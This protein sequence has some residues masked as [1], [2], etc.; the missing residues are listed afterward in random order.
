MTSHNH[1]HNHHNNDNTIS[2]TFVPNSQSYADDIGAMFFSHCFSVNAGHAFEEG[3]IMSEDNGVLAAAASTSDETDGSDD[4]DETRTASTND[5]ERP[6][7]QRPLESKRSMTAHD[8]AEEHSRPKKAS[9]TPTNAPDGANAKPKKSCFQITVE[10]IKYVYSVT[11]LVVSVAIVMAAIFTEQTTMAS[12]V[13]PWLAF[14]VIWALIL[15]LAMMEG[16]QGCLVGLQPI[17]KQL[18]A[19]SHPVSLR[20]TT[21]AHQGDNMRRFIVGRQF[22]VVLVVFIVNRCGAAIGEAPSV[23]GFPPLVNEIF[24][25]SGLAMIMMTITLGQLTAQINASIASLDFI[26]NYGMLFTTYVSLAIEFSGL[27]HAVYLV[28]YIFSKIAGTPIESKE[29]PRRALSNI[30]FWGRVFVS[31]AILGY[32]FAVVLSALF[33]GKTT[34]YA[35]VPGW[36][37]VVILFV[38]MGVVGLL[39][40]VQIAL[41]AVVN[42]PEDEL[43]HHTLAAK[44]CEL[45]FRDRNLPAFLIGRQIFTTICM[46]TV[47]KITSIN[48]DITNADD[49]DNIFGVSN[50]LQGFFNTGLL[51]AIITTIVASLAWRI[52][53]ASFPV[54]FLSNPLVYVI[55]QVCLF[56]EASGICSAAW[57]LAWVL[58]KV[59]GFY[60]DE[61]YI[62]TAEQRGAAAVDETEAEADKDD[63]DSIFGE[64]L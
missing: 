55:V 11:F 14:Y 56:F 46:F 58:K 24:L 49:G 4:K 54:A 28:Q 64:V 17:D 51:G 52:I 27:L 59:I 38:L 9:T 2:R 63:V 21:L 19:P 43:T 53:A 42:L 5:I 62:G 50:A 15:W 32:A 16:G 26:N 3:T 57:L 22:L 39:E 20:C 40:G 35:G 60:R 12:D 34:M 29:P 25:S 18:Y 6:Q 41:F 8:A 48:V 47:S 10:T 7:Q 1:H 23:F 36:A 33:Q 13:S 30:L 45:V 61:V 44:T 31:V 37:S